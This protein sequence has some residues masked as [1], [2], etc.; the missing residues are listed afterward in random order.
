VVTSTVT[1]PG[2]VSAE[3]VARA[4]RILLLLTDCDGVLTDGGTY[5]SER[6]EE[7]KRF[8][9]RDGMGVERLRRHGSVETGI[10]TSEAS[11]PVRAR[12]EK[13]G[14]TELHLGVRDKGAVVR[15]VAGRRGLEL[16]EIAFLGDDV[17]DVPALEL[18]GLSA[19]PVDA[20][21]TVRARV[22]FVCPSAGGHGAF[23]DLAE[24]ILRARLG[25]TPGP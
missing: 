7:F 14:I 2:S 16:D 11:G 18:C 10:V 1:F 13:L 4:R 15:E 25:M 20:F 22:H 9:L 3:T 23:R 21:S 19:C 12:A 8:S 6:G 24:L 5:C 17:N